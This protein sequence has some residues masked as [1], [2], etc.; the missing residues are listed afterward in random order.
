[1]AGDLRCL[2]EQG[3]S[4]GRITLHDSLNGEWYQQKA[5]HDALYLPL[6]ED[7]LGS[8]EPAGCG[9][10]GAAELQ[11]HREPACGSR[12]AFAVATLEE[13]AM[14]PFP[15]RLAVVLPSHEIG[16][17][18]EPFEVLRFQRGFP[19]GGLEQAIRVRP[20]LLLEGLT[21]TRE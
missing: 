4:R 10:A 19:I 17:C 13:R 6:V 14:R 8:R 11:P 3:L 20:S 5:A 16:G 18:R 1:L 12:G 21:G 9:S 15:E 2:T 7:A